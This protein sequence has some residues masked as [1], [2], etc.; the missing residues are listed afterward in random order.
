MKKYLRN[1]GSLGDSNIFRVS[2]NAVWVVAHSIHPDG[3]AAKAKEQES[4]GYPMHDEVERVTA[5]YAA[6]ESVCLDTAAE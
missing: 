5:F 2:E 6:S 3:L 1:L 4:F